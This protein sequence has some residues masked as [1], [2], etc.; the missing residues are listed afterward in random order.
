MLPGPVF[1][2]ELLRTGR[3]RRYY[4]LRVA[5]GALLLATFWMVFG[6]EMRAN[7]EVD[8][9]RIASAAGAVCAVFLV[10]QAVVVAV[11]TPALVAGAIVDER[12]RK[13]LHYLLSS[14][15]TGPEI[16]VGKLAARLLHV[17]VLG[18]IGVPVLALLGLLGGVDP[19]L[20]GY[21]YGATAAGVWALAGLSM[22]VSVHARRVRE[23]IV[24]SLALG[25]AWLL[26]PVLLRHGTG[27]PGMVRIK[28][29]TDPIADVVYPISPF[30]LGANVA[31]LARPGKAEAVAWSI[32][33]LVAVG[34][35]LVALAVL[36]LRPVARRDGAE[37]ARRRWLGRW[38]WPRPP[39]GDRPMLWKER[40]IGRKGGVLGALVRVLGLLG[41]GVLV[42]Q[43]WGSIGDA[44]KYVRLYGY[45]VEG[46]LPDERE[47]LGQACRGVVAFVFAL[48]G[49]A[50]SAVAAGGVTAEREEDTWTS[51]TTTDLTAG[52]IVGAKILGATRGPRPL[53]ATIL[54][55]MLLSMALGGLH[56]AGLVLAVVGLAL[57]TWFYAALGTFVSL[58]ARTTT[59]A[60]AVT[61]GIVGFLG[62][63]YLF[64]CIPLRPETP[65]AFLGVSP[66]MLFFAQLTH[67]DVSGLMGGGRGRSLFGPR[68]HPDQLALGL[69][70]SYACHGL[71][72]AGLT[73]WSI[74]GFDAAVDRPTRAGRA[75][76]AP[77]DEGG[78]AP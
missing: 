38:R 21:A 39:V 48:W 11:M 66:M 63:G 62:G 54:G 51:L 19:S 72:A 60:L 77:I 41:L 32:A 52:E 1:N 23:A 29:F 59:G 65:A 64:C 68:D 26:V 56:P 55:L 76:V 35:V 33:E 74:L 40:F 15:L 22:L 46:A 45:G 10:I 18:A 44:Y 3:Q 17:A 53:L 78:D 25:V 42:Y 70:L 36:R 27:G 20:V 43:L 71:A 14:R 28:V 7:V 73:A 30:G 61:L 69:A 75:P 16:V 31:E 13:T 50:V 47:Q 37:R 4:V 58:H 6:T 34:T 8:P 57:Y 12:Q 2:V 5:Y 24:A 67:G 9:R 49:L